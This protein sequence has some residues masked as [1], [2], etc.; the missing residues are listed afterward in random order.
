MK[1]KW[2]LYSKDLGRY[3]S[4]EPGRF[5]AITTQRI[6][7][8]LDCH[9]GKQAKPKN[10]IFLRYLEDMPEGFRACKICRP[11]VLRVGDRLDYLEERADTLEREPHVSLWATGI[12][13]KNDTYEPCRWYVAMNWKHRKG[14]RL[15]SGQHTLSKHHL[16][17]KAFSLALKEGRRLNIP[18]IKHG[19]LDIVVLWLPTRRSTAEQKGLVRSFQSGEVKSIFGNGVIMYEHA[20]SV[21]SRR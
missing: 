20:E 8:R 9:S 6:A 13:R 21:F 12:V 7:G 17:H 18:V 1:K 2:N 19:L 5:A 11:E 15:F 3:Q 14:R 4:S 10:R 16:Y